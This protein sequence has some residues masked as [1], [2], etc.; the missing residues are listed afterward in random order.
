MPNDERGRGGKPSRVQVFHFPKREKAP[1]RTMEEA[2]R[3]NDRAQTLTIPE[4]RPEAAGDDD[5]VTEPNYV[6]A[7]PLADQ[8]RATPPWP[9]RTPSGESRK[10]AA[11]KR[12]DKKRRAVGRRKSTP[13][14]RPP[15]APAQAAPSAAA[16]KAAPAKMS[17]EEAL[18]GHQLFEMGRLEEARVVFEGLVGTEPKDAFPYTML[19]TIYLAL[20][21]QAR[22]LALFEAALQ[23]DTD[24]IA[25]LVYR[26]E[27]RLNQGKLK[28]AMVDLNRAVQLGLGDDPFVDRAR[29]LIRMAQDRARQPPS[30]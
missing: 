27:I 9:R 28:P 3:V 13:V 25:A 17:P 26:G 24:E 5:F 20:G 30:R 8:S 4:F 16:A 7:D 15:A 10:G 12:K 29:R 21:D 18:F 2:L 22:A 19:G 11:G 23:I 14:D 6:A 1:S